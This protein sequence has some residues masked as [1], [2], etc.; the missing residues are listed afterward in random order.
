VLKGLGGN[1]FLHGGTGNDRLYGNSGKDAFV[2]DTKPHKSANKDVIQDFNV[3]D[4]TIRLENSS[5][6]KVGKSG[7]VLSSSM[8]WA[9]N[10]GKAHDK[11]D[12][13]I[14]DKDSGVLYYDPDG[15]GS[16]KAV[17]FTNIQKKLAMTHKDIY[18]I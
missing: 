2:F 8:F 18:L 13:I 7:A 16:A 4:D 15:T 9:N 17:A 5:F 10:T 6:T 12:R 14:Y 1:D 11:S 3:R